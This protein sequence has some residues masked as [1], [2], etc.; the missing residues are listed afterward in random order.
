[1][2]RNIASYCRNHQFH[3]GIFMCGVAHRKSILEKLSKFNSQEE[4]N[5]N[6]M[7]YNGSTTQ[8]L[9]TDV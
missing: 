6:W 1:M 3:T 8:L 5:V 4:V 9:T 2:L 7:I